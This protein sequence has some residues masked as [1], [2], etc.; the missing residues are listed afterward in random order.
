MIKNNGMNEFNGPGKRRKVRD[1][2]REHPDSNG[3]ETNATSVRESDRDKPASETDKKI[4]NQDQQEQ[5][6][7]T[8]GNNDAVRED[9]NEGD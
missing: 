7:N 8:E 5:I 6:T 3:E 2:Q 9:T 1:E 4:T